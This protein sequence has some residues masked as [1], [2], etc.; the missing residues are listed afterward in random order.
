MVSNGRRNYSEA[1]ENGVDV[2]FRVRLCDML[3]HDLE[4]SK[5]EV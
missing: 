1:P 2:E 5:Q 3:H 4:L